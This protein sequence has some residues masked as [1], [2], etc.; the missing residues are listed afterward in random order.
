MRVTRAPQGHQ[1]ESQGHP[2]G[3]NGGDEII[4]GTPM[5]PE[6]RPIAQKNKKSLSDIGEDTKIHVSRRAW[7]T[8]EQNMA[9]T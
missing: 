1:W 9:Q 5:E 8:Q 6:E 7:K 2:E 3:T 4:P